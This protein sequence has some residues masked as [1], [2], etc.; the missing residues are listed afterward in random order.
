MLVCALDHVSE[1]ARY[2]H[3]LYEQDWLRMLVLFFCRKFS[4]LDGEGGFE[5]TMQDK[6][7]LTGVYN[8]LGYSFP[9]PS[10]PSWIGANGDV[11]N[12]V[13]N[14]S[15][16]NNYGLFRDQI[17]ILLTWKELP[18]HC[19]LPTNTPGCLTLTV[20]RYLPFLAYLI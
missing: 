8:K 19:D 1:S 3:V 10:G 16:I 7:L 15:S 2:V 9:T 17:E 20:F 4:F 13:L 12:K 5:C 11:S 6:L 14:S 18:G